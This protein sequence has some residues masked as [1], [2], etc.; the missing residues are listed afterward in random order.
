MKALIISEETDKS[1]DVVCSWLQ[2]W[3]HPYVRVNSESFINPEV[4]IRAFDEDTSVLI[5]TRGIIVDLND[6]QTVWFRR[7]YLY[8]KLSYYGD[9][10]S[11]EVSKELNK[12]IENESSTLTHFIYAILSSKKKIN[13]PDRYNFNKL[14]ALHE[15][16]RLGLRIPE[17]LV[18]GNGNIIKGFVR[19]NGTCIT[20]SIQDMSS[21]TVD[22]V[23][24]SIGKITQVKAEDVTGINYWYSLFQQEIP[25]KYEL[26]V[27][28]FLDRMYAMAIFSQMDNLSLF[29]YREVDVNGFH[30]NRMVPFNLSKNVKKKIHKLMK[31]LKLESGS[32]DM[33]VTPEN[34]YVFL[35]I[36]PV[37]Q[38]N[39]VSEIC[40]YYIERDI[41]KNLTK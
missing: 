5:N 27:F 4:V 6:I 12:H 26:R 28:Y 15:A 24:Y 13:H 16:A 38:F 10:I 35:E 41:A 25:K 40:N 23:N 32:I 22:G 39:F 33:I 30:P 29:D 18:C 21:V 7:G 1:C 2:K 11:K 37:G 31:K 8:I 36:N 17:T 3:Q 34:E 19:D 20:K 14:I 9:E